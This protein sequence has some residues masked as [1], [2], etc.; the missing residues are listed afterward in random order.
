MDDGG[1][2]GGDVCREQDGHGGDRVEVAVTRDL[3]RRRRKQWAMAEAGRAELGTDG[4]RDG[5]VIT[6][7]VERK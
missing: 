3:R 7:F 4:Q 6:D 5:G 2:E 1:D